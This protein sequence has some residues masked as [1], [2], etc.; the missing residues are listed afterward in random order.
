[1]D[2]SLIELLDAFKRTAALGVPFDVQVKPR[3]PA[4]PVNADCPAIPAH[5]VDE[6]AVEPPVLKLMF[7]YGPE[8]LATPPIANPVPS[9][10]YRLT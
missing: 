1:M 6:V 8:P 7:V 3:I 2:T 10:R 9:M 5:T 4:V